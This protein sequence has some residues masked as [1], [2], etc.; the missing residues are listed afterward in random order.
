VRALRVLLAPEFTSLTIAAPSMTLKDYERDA[1]CLGHLDVERDGVT[2]APLYAGGLS[3]AGFVAGYPALLTRLAREVRRADLVH[4]GP[5]HDV[6]RP[7]EMPAIVLAWLFGRKTLAVADIDLRNDARMNLD[8]GAWTRTEY[9]RCRWLYDPVRR[10]QLHLVGAFCSLVLFKGRRLVEDFGR[11]RAV[12]HSFLDAAFSSDHLLDEEALA[13]KVEALQDPTR[14]LEL[15]YFGRLV[16]YKGL[17]RV[18]EAMALVRGAGDRGAGSVRLRVIGTGPEEPRLKALTSALGLEDA[19]QFLGPRP[20]GPALFRELTDVE[21][22]V[23]APLSADTPRSAL[24]ALAS[25]IGILA[26]DVDYYRD[27]ATTSGAIELVP[28]GSVEA[29]AERIEHLAT[30]RSELVPRVRKAVEFARGNSQEIWLERRAQW[31]KALFRD[32]VGGG[33]GRPGWH[34]GGSFGTR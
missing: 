28:W 11:Q 5:S 18:L 6:K 22:L 13:R 33:A 24:D 34:T 23:A 19:V 26:F 12:V 4:A 17:D 8:T 27:L 31:T 7:I 32:E 25:G 9:L 29:L 20:F 14:P 3:T 21:L 30:H 15:G 1:E 16:A 2:F 10:G